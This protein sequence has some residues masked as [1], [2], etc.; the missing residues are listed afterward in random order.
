MRAPGRFRDR[1]KIVEDRETLDVDL[2]RLAFTSK[3]DVDELYDDID[4]VLATTGRSWY[5]AI[6]Y[7]DCTIADEI[8]E[9]FGERG[10]HA[11]VTYGLGTV[12]YGL[13]AP[14]RQAMRTRAMQEGF[15]ANVFET[16]AD[17]LGA[18]AE[19]R[20]RR[21]VTGAAATEALLGVRDVSVN[22]GGI[23]AL[24]D[25]SFDVQ[26][27]EIF[28]IIG[29]NGAGKTS[30]VNVI[31]GFYHPDR[32]QILFEGKDRTRLKAFEVAE[33]GIA[34]TFQNVALLRA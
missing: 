19:L 9:H 1:V 4:R 34:R 26:T 24:R 17:A 7:T 2:S 28:S 27:G 6:D 21:R 12:R 10:R 29:P 3:E 5:F 11:E 30:A 25:V 33:L 20:K 16:R 18:V 14:T 8:W 15:R 13:A 23:K 22:F 31:S 32:G